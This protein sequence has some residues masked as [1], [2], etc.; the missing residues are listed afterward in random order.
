MKFLFSDSAFAL[1][2]ATAVV[3]VP[4]GSVAML[5]LLAISVVSP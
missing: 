5:V 4:V 3:I 1:L 2:M